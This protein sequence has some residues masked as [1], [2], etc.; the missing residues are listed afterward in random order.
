M[1]G[2]SYCLIENNRFYGCS[3]GIRLSGT[4]HKVRGNLIGHSDR[5]GIRLLYG[6]TKEQGGHTRRSAIAL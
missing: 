4:N 1:R 2:G 3:G 5:T 6:M